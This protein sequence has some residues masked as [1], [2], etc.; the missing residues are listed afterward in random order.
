MGN[1]K[2][3]TELDVWIVAKALTKSIY[4]ITATFPSTENY[5][6][7]DQM[8]RAA[9]SVPSNIAEGLGRNTNPDKKRFLYIARGS[10]FELETQV[11]IAFDLGYINDQSL[12]VLKSEILSVKKLLN[13]LINFLKDTKN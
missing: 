12:K 8:C 4:K 5:R 11:H 3:F 6:L 10:A 1:L 2:D 7:T 9:V 13:G